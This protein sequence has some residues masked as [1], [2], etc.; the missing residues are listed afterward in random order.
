M[1]PL[2]LRNSLNKKLNIFFNFFNPFF[3]SPDKK[4]ISQ[5]RN[6]LGFTP[7][8]IAVYK[9]AFRHRNAEEVRN[10]IKFSNERLE[11]L[12]DAILGAVIAD[13]L[14]KKFPYK[15]EGFLTNMR[16][17]IVNREHM[18]KL[19]IK[20]GI[21]KFA[22][23]ESGQRSKSVYG[24]ALEAFIG[25]IYLDKGYGTCKKYILQHLI[26]NLVDIDQ[27]ETIEVNFKSK[28]IEWAQREKKSITFELVE[29]IKVE[30][31]KQLKVRA[32]VDGLEMGMGIDFS[33]KKAEQIA[34]QETCLLLKI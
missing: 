3:S 31:Q 6:M 14:F 15:D 18:N 30:N 26:G 21:N 7:G 5:L 1:L 12:G 34:A 9:L 25:A 27:L 13:M 22:V 10:G 19:A 2:Y 8:N 16:S 28:L 23:F 29:E 20:I 17:K 4:F 11:F 32:L 33:K 24:D